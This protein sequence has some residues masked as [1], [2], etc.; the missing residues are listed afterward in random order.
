[1]KQLKVLLISFLFTSTCLN[2]QWEV[3]YDLQMM[4]FLDRVHFVDENYGWTIGGFSFGA[5]PGP[6]YYTIDGGENWLNTNNIL[7]YD[8]IFMNQENGFI[9]ASDGVIRK[10]VNGGEIWTDNQTPALQD[11]LRL[12]FVDE[13]NGWATLDNLTVD[14][15]ID[16]TQ[17]VHTTDGGNTWQTQQVS[18]FITSHIS[19]I[20]FISSSIGYGGG[21]YD[22]YENDEHYSFIVKTQDGGETWEVVYQL[23]NTFNFIFDLYFT[24]TMTGWAVGEN[25]L[26]NTTDGGITWQ[27]NS[28]PLIDGGNSL[29]EINVIYSVFFANDTLGWLTCADE[30]YNGYVFLTTDSGQIWQQQFISFD[31]KLIYDINVVDNKNGWAVGFDII[32]HSSNSD[33]IIVSGTGIEESNFQKN[34]IRIIPN[35]TS[36]IF[37]VYSPFGNWQGD[38]TVSIINNLGKQIFSSKFK[39]FGNQ[40]SFDITEQPP[41]VYYITVQYLM[42]NQ[43]NILTKKIFKL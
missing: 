11:V 12:F 7:G 42:N 14:A 1:M 39:S 23:Q 8:I 5:G 34:G 10:T 28:M 6:Y 26:L 4:T 2:A 33:T 24:D 38:F 40:L 13:N 30:E 36:G 16:S 15:V 19:S 43:I 41:G 27:E 25:L 9:A 20:Y 31:N 18:E 21:W 3:Q 32:Y 22:D 17:L 37:T 29:L 35:P